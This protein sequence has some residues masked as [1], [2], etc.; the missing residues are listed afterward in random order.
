MR[1]ELYLDDC[2]FSHRLRKLLIEAG[3]NVQIP[4]DVEPSLRGARDETHFQHVLNTQQI[5][6]TLNPDDFHELHQ[7]YPEHA[8]VFAVYRDNDPSR[9][10]TLQRYSPSNRQHTTTWCHNQ[11]CFLVTERLSVVKVG[12]GIETGCRVHTYVL[13]EL[14]AFV[15]MTTLMLCRK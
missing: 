1:L 3:H 12:L 14:S 9:D 13:S 2:A 8:G 7:K 4:A 11:R 15:L 10:M 5:I 6:L